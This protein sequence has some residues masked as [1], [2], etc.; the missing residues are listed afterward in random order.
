MRKLL[1]TA[2]GLRC[3]TTLTMVIIIVLNV[4]TV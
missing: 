3:P 1:N 4:I 2:N